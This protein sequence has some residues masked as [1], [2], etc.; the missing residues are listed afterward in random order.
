MPN[1]PASYT[2]TDVTR[3]CKGTVAAGLKVKE[4][5]ASN[6]GVRVIID[7]GVK[8][9]TTANEWDEVLNEAP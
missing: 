5:F 7:D 3:A 4:V 9:N 1:R 2:Q 6:D 8:K